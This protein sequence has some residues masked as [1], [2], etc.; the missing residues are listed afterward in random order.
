MKKMERLGERIQCF[1]CFMVLPKPTPMNC[2]HFFL[3]NKLLFFLC[4]L[5]ISTPI[6]IPTSVQVT[7]SLYFQ[8]RFLNLTSESLCT[9]LL[10]ISFLTSHSIQIQHVPNILLIISSQILSFS[11]SLAQCLTLIVILFLNTLPR[12]IC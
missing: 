8:P 1:S 4:I 10:S 12:N 7:H 9:S 6:S 3:I 2:Q 5:T 11:F